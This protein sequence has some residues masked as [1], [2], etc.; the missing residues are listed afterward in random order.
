MRVVTNDQMSA[1]LVAGNK[2]KADYLVS[3]VEAPLREWVNENEASLTAN[4]LNKAFTELLDQAIKQDV[5]EI[6]LPFDI[7]PT[8]GG[9]GADNA[10]RGFYISTRVTKLEPKTI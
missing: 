6:A 10:H 7:N 3:K 8:Y 1:L 4:L 2:D 9:N 5:Q